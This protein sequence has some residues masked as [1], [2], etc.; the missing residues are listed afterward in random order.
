LDKQ[1]TKPDR[2]QIPLVADTTARDALYTTLAGGELVEVTS[3][4][5]MQRYNAGTA[6]WESLAAGTPTPNAST[7]VS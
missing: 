3:L 2:I 6:Q 7:T 4:G 5:A 1:F